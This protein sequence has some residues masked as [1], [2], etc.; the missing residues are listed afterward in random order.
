MSP[1]QAASSTPRHMRQDPVASIGSK[2]YDDLQ[3]ALSE[4]G[5]GTVVLLDDIKLR[6]RILIDAPHTTF[7][8]NGHTIQFAPRLAVQDP[9]EGRSFLD[10]QA[11]DVKIC[12]GRIECFSGAP[13]AV[14][15]RTAPVQ[16]LTSTAFIERMSIEAEYASTGIAC[17]AGGAMCTRSQIKSTGVGIVMRGPQARM[18]LIDATV[19]ARRAG[20][21][22]QGGKLLA[23]DSYISAH[24]SC[25]IFVNAGTVNLS[26][27]SVR[28]YRERAIATHLTL[29]RSITGYTSPSIDIRNDCEI[30]SFPSFA[31]D[32]PSGSVCIR[33]SEVRSM[34]HTSIRIGTE[35]LLVSPRLSSYGHTVIASWKAD[36]IL[37]RSGILDL[38][39]VEFKCDRGTDIVQE[40]A[41]L[42][43]ST[44]EVPAAPDE[45]TSE[46]AQRNGQ[47]MPAE[48]TPDAGAETGDSEE[49]DQVE[50]ASPDSDAEVI[51]ESQEDTGA[52]EDETA[53][54]T[55][56]ESAEQVDGPGEDSGDF[57]EKQPRD[58]EADAEVPEDAQEKAQARDAETQETNSANNESAKKEPKP[59][60]SVYIQHVH[61]HLHATRPVRFTGRIDVAA[62]HAKIDFEQWTNGTDIVTS[63]DTKIP[64]PGTTYRYIIA[65]K[66][67]SGYAF[68]KRFK[69][70]YKGKRVPYTAMISTDMKIAMTSWSLTAEVPHLRMAQR[71][72]L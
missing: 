20:V 2:S 63:T 71:L 51:G 55:Q 54:D 70:Y 26:R 3:K 67:E 5:D 40:R 22:V 12:N 57:E 25:A 44:D 56:S 10:I 32:L 23:K 9:Y 69:L 64:Q 28:A 33:D 48:T 19:K 14:R 6:H 41:L 13:Y 60:E 53:E 21:L 4:A 38:N 31:I 50:N 52:N 59:I 17:D 49:T 36:G 11:P 30:C 65:L 46:D 34:E 42:D 61:T 24:W 43:S 72:F 35:N 1:L 58:T 27:T 15:V 62:S 16:K 8:L 39:D 18:G 7:D 68:S 29:T 47:E 66:A 37:Q 45:D